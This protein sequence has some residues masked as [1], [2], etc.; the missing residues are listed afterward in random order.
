VGPGWQPIGELGAWVSF[1]GQL[2]RLGVS[3]VPHDEVDFFAQLFSVV[4]CPFTHAPSAPQSL[5]ARQGE[6][7]EPSPTHTAAR[8]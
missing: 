2:P 8:G 6:Q 7:S 5:S 4:N 3:A 1:A